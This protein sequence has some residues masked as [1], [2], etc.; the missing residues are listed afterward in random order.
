MQILTPLDSGAK[1]EQYKQAL[2]SWLRRPKVC[3]MDDSDKKAGGAILGGAGA[4][5]VSTVATQ[6]FPNAPVLLWQ[7]LFV[8][9]V[10]A[11][12]YGAVSGVVHHLRMRKKPAIRRADIP[13]GKYIV[14]GR[15]ED[16]PGVTIGPMSPAEALK[17]WKAPEPEY[18]PIE[19]AGRWLY[20]NASP[21]IREVLKGGVP[22]PFNSI[23]EHGSALYRTQWIE[24][25]CA[26]Y[27]RWEPGL[28]ME[29]I[30]PKDGKF[31]AFELVFGS[32]RRKPIDLSVLKQDLQPVLDHYE[33]EE[34]A[35]TSR[36]MVRI[37]RDTPLRE[38][39]MFIVTGQWG[40]NP[41]AD[42]GDHLKDLTDA[43]ADFRQHASDGAI[44]VWGKAGEFGV[45]QRIEPKYWQNHYV[46]F[47]DLLR[48][49]ARTTAANQL[50]DEPLF[51]ELMV[52][53]A[54]FEWEW[55]DA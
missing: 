1:S 41:M 21:K 35:A 18:I 6:A 28:P 55:R 15:A 40:L 30:D 23:A 24:G 32:P 33:R 19:D 43:L 53:R 13:H 2:P 7:A 44:T 29:P 8:I 52:S 49:E 50:G 36:E 39:L 22:S 42:G 31:S 5:L 20:E 54:E 12:A 14:G 4:T 11:M 25:R 47:L 27:G 51:Q 3:P 38:A 10:I 34:P 37:L 17:L 16:E 9:G 45:W 26:L 46:N 48:S